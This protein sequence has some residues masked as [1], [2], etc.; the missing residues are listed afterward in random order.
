MKKIFF[1]VAIAAFSVA[2]LSPFYGAQAAQLNVDKK[3]ELNAKRVPADKPL[4]MV[5]PRIP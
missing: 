2:S 3:S 1:I 4:N 5:A